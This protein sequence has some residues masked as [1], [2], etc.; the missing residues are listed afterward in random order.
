MAF[1]MGGDPGGGM[2]AYQ[3]AQ[4]NRGRKT[5]ARTLR[6]VA[7]AFAPDIGQVA[8]VVWPLREQ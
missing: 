8:L 5:D 7:R 1:A 6:R 4:K 3:D 2:R